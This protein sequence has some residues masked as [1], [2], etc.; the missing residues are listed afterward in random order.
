MGAPCCSALGS[1]GVIILARSAGTSAAAPRIPFTSSTKACGESKAVVRGRW[2]CVFAL[3][4]R[5]C[6]DA[7]HKSLR[8]ENQGEPTVRLLAAARTS[9]TRGPNNK[10]VPTESRSPPAAGRGRFRAECPEACAPKCGVRTGG[11]RR[12]GARGRRGRAA[13][14]PLPAL[15]EAGRGSLGLGGGHATA[16]MRASLECKSAACPGPRCCLMLA[17]WW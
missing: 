15:G 16:C 4:V 6:R 17:G 1:G 7:L 3:C 13:A 2:H 5:A 8:I 10:Q 11:S 14:A 9:N 12:R